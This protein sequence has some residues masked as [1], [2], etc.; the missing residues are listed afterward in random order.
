[1]RADEEHELWIQEEAEDNKETMVG[2]T[3]NVITILKESVNKCEMELIADIEVRK[4]KKRIFS[5]C[6]NL[7]NRTQE[8]QYL[9]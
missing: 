6:A 2:V 1:M 4:Y 7:E 3:G 9:H 5:V 8:L